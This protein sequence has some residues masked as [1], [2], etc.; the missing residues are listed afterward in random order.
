[1][2]ESGLIGSWLIG[3]WDG[4]NFCC[5][6]YNPAADNTAAFSGGSADYVYNQGWFTNE[7]HVAG[8]CSECGDG[9]APVVISDSSYCLGRFKPTQLQRNNNELGN[10]RTF[11]D[12]S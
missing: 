2:P 9:C 11:E 7:C 3:V 4:C 1:M 8:T 12:L 10:C 6:G 5:G